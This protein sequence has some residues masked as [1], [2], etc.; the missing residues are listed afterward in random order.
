MISRNLLGYTLSSVLRCRTWKQRI[1][2]HRHWPLTHQTRRSLH[3]YHWMAVTFT[4]AILW[5]VFP[6]EEFPV[7]RILQQSI[8]VFGIILG[9][10]AIYWELFCRRTPRPKKRFDSI[11]SSFLRCMFIYLWAFLAAQ[12]ILSSFAGQAWSNGDDPMTPAMKVM[13]AKHGVA[14]ASSVIFAAATFVLYDL[15]R[16]R[17]A[18]ERT[19]SCDEPKSR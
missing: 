2:T 4:T 10:P 16:S 8:F 19:E 13:Y 3:P 15:W 9:M 14:N 11:N 18:P 7:R 17:R 6:V 1:P 5:A 12:F